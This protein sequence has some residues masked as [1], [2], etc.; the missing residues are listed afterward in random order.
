MTKDRTQSSGEGEAFLF[1][2][3]N[4]SDP[5][6]LILNRIF[7]RDDLVFITLDFI[8]SGIQGRGLAATSRPRNQDHAIRFGNVMTEAFDILVIKTND[9]E[10]Q[11]AKLLAH[12]FFVENAQHG[13]FS[14]NGRHDGNAEVD[15]TIVIA[16]TKTTV[17]RNAPLRD[18]E[19]AHHL[20]TR[21]DGRVV[22]FGDRL[23]RVLQHAVDTILNYH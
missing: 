1:I 15:E 22:L 21:D 10:V 17:L 14:V 19:L 9:V 18:V 6:D 7:D 5:P 4:L 3:G 12:R 11:L 8:E 23:H 20:D 16:D 2:D 13:I